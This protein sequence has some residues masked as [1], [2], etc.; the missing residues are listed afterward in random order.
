VE[1]IGLHN[2]EYKKL[3]W[4]SFFIIRG[5]KIKDFTT[6]PPLQGKTFIGCPIIKMFIKSC[7]ATHVGMESV[8]S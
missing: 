3:A 4:P 5:V 2:K 7:P 1:L 6:A 8:L